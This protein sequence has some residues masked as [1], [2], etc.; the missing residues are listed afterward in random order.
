M[1]GE[2]SSGSQSRLPKRRRRG[3][4]IETTDRAHSGPPSRH[5]RLEPAGLDPRGAPPGRVRRA[6]AHAGNGMPR[7][8]PRQRRGNGLRAGRAGDPRAH[9]RRVP[10]QGLARARRPLHGRRPGGRRCRIRAGPAALA[11]IGAP[12]AGRRR[13]RARA[14]PPAP[15]RHGTNTPP[16]AARA[17]GARLPPLDPALQETLGEADRRARRPAPAGADE[18]AGVGRLRRPAGGR[19]TG[20]R[21]ALRAGRP[22]AFARLGRHQQVVASTARGDRAPSFRARSLS[23]LRNRQAAT[24]RGRGRPDTGGGADARGASARRGGRR[25][26]GAASARPRFGGHAPGAA[27]DGAT[28]GSRLPWPSTRAR[29]GWEPCSNRWWSGSSNGTR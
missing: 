21:M 17:G 24:R 6:G 4:R 1:S 27:R 14:R 11:E 7:D 2:G 28:T 16:R 29:V 23:A 3:A 5:L 12:A 19:A 20:V 13:A 26:G 10:Q 18:D 15:P 8:A 9:G 22:G 25:R